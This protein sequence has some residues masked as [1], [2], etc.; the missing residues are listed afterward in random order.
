MVCLHLIG[1]K[2]VVTREYMD[3]MKNGCIVCNMGHSNTEI[4][5][6]SSCVMCTCRSLWGF[7]LEA[8]K[9]HKPLLRFHIVELWFTMTSCDSHCRGVIHNVELWF[10]VLSCD[11]QWWAVIHNDELW[12]TLSSCDSH[13]RP[14]IHIV[15]LWFTLSN[16]DSHC[17]AVIH[18]IELWF[19]MLSCDSQWWA[20]IHNVEL[21]HCCKFKPLLKTAEICK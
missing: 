6:V 3:K 8:F 11:S 12:F 4:D 9:E 13:C 10:T 18:S 5:V 19:T 21:W 14:V 17:R 7:Q 16:C 20:V 15:D 2:N 1:N